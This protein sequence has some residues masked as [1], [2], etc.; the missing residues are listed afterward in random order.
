MGRT[1]SGGPAPAS[2]LRDHLDRQRVVCCPGT[3]TRRTTQ[4]V[5]AFH[6]APRSSFVKTLGIL[7]LGIA[8]TIG[9]FAVLHYISYS[10]LRRPHYAV[11]KQ[12]RG[13]WLADAY[14]YAITDLAVIFAG[15]KRS[16]LREEW[17]AHLFGDPDH[18]LSIWR[19]LCDASGFI[20]AAICF[21]LQDAA[22]LAWIPIDAVLKSRLLSNLIVWLSTITAITIFFRHG[23]IYDVIG[24]AENISAIA[25][26]S[27]TLV[28][29]G[30]WWR[31]VKPR[32]PQ[33]HYGKHGQDRS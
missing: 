16:G 13:R 14:A 29:V 9:M 7:V 1:H 8:L 25:A 24:N 19:R 17:C 6:T 12:Q 33:S 21:R 4:E 22:E 31:R 20:V 11:K 27:Y 30:R 2:L 28:R 23:G 10:S 18:E 3:R 32:N 15:R 5:V 26:A